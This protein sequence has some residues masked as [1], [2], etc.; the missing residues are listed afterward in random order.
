MRLR[1]GDEQRPAAP[2]RAD[3]DHDAERDLRR[4]RTRVPVPRRWRNDPP[5]L[6]RGPRDW[7]GDLIVTPSVAT[8]YYLDVR[9]SASPSTCSATDSDDH[10]ARLLDRRHLARPARPDDDSLAGEGGTASTP[11][12]GTSRRFALRAA[13]SPARAASRTTVPTRSRPTRSSRAP[14]RPTTTWR[15]ATARRGTIRRIPGS[16]GRAATP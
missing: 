2:L 12:K 13:V 14:A 9:C 7:A 15:A 5:R 10:D 8:T 3:R 4:R 16:R 11:Q 1:H 6:E